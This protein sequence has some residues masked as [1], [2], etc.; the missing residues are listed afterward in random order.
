MDQENGICS[1]YD[2]FFR[3]YGAE[4]RLFCPDFHPNLTHKQTYRPSLAK[5]VAWRCR[6]R[7]EMLHSFWF[8]A[9]WF[10]IEAGQQS[11]E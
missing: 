11:R 2:E 4:V 1:L 10:G 8:H 7:R 3:A 9:D 6:P 5:R